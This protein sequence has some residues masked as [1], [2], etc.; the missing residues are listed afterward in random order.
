[1]AQ[2]LDAFAVDVT[3][4]SRHMASNSGLSRHSSSTSWPT[5]ETAPARA[6]SAR[7]A[8]TTKRATLSQSYCAAPHAGVA[9]R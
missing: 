7:N 3:S 4:L 5:S 6:A 9:R 8:P 2:A 1:M